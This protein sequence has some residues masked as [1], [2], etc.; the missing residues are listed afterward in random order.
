[1]RHGLGIKCCFKDE[2]IA[3]VKMC[4]SSN[5]GNLYK[6]LNV[7]DGINPNDSVS[8]VG[9]KHSSQRSNTSGKSSP[10]SSAQMNVERQL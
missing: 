10:T 9:S 2:C 6:N 4:V 7:E 1:M 3:D 8:N 5:E